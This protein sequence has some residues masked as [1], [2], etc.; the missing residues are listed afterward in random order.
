MSDA[1]AHINIDSRI[2]AIKRGVGELDGRAPAPVYGFSPHMDFHG[3][4][5]ASDN[6]LLETYRKAVIRDCRRMSAGPVYLRWRGI[7]KSLATAS[8]GGQ[9]H[10]L[11]DGD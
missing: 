8:I 6:K 9:Q 4:S 10:N 3:Y 5:P 2:A 7:D 1:H 11:V